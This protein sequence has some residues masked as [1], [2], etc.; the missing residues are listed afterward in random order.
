ISP[1]ARIEGVSS[2]PAGWGLSAM[3]HDEETVAEAARPSFP[4]RPDGIDRP[5]SAPRAEPPSSPTQSDPHARLR[6]LSEPPPSVMSAATAEAT[7]LVRRQEESERGRALTVVAGAG[8]VA[9]LAA[10]LIGDTGPPSRWVAVAFMSATALGAGGGFLA[11]RLGYAIGPRRLLAMGLLATASILALIVHIGVFSLAVVP[12]FIGVYYFGMTDA[13]RDG[14]AMF[15]LASVGYSVLVG[16]T[17]F[18]VL[19]P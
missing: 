17:L 16:L 11:D 8:A 2:P 4:S 18:G 9:T 12:L 14:W 15:S 10:L 3:D 13:R 7:T 1:D 6:P 19:N 5:S